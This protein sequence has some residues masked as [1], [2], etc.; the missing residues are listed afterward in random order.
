LANATYKGTLAGVNTGIATVTVTNP[1]GAGVGDWM[2]VE[3][4]TSSSSSTVTT[5]PAGWVLLADSGPVNTRHAFSYAKI[6]TAD[7]PSSWDFILNAAS[8][9]SWSIIYGAGGLGISDWKKRTY[10]NDVNTAFGYDRRYTYYLEQ[11]AASSASA[12]YVTRI[13]GNIEAVAG[14]LVITWAGEATSAAETED[15]ITATG[16]TKKL[17]YPGSGSLIYTHWIGADTMTAAGMTNDVFVTY[18]NLQNS[19]GM[20]HQIVIPPTV[21]APTTPSMTRVVAYDAEDATMPFSKQVLADSFERTTVNP[22]SGA[23]SYRRVLG[24]GAGSGST[25][26]SKVPTGPLAAAKLQMQ[27]AAT[28]PEG[29]GLLVLGDSMLEG[30]GQTAVEKRIVDMLAA[31]IATLVEAKG[32]SP[33]V[34]AFYN[35]AYNNPSQPPVNAGPVWSGSKTVTTIPGLGRRAYA[36]GINATVTLTRVVS[37]MDVHMVM[38]TNDQITIKWGTA[39]PIT[40]GP[41]LVGH[42]VFKDPAGIASTPRSRACLIARVAGGPV[43][44]GYMAYTNNETTGVRVLDASKHGTM[45]YQFTSVRGPNGDGWHPSLDEQKYHMGLLGHVTNDTKNGETAQTWTD[46]TLRNINVL[47]TRANDGRLP[48]LIFFPWEPYKL[49]AGIWATFRA[50]AEAIKANDQYVE[51]ADFSTVIKSQQEKIDQDLLAVND[52]IHWNDKGALMAEQFL[53]NVITEN[54]T[55]TKYVAPTGGTGNGRPLPTSHAQAVTGTAG[56]SATPEGYIYEGWVRLDSDTDIALG[57]LTI[58]ATG[59]GTGGIQAL[60]DARNGTDNASTFQLKYAM[61]VQPVAKTS[62]S[63]FPVSKGQKYR[64]RILWKQT[65]PVVTAYFY[66]AAGTL[67]QTLTTTTDYPAGRLG[68][69]SYGSVTF[70]DL[71]FDKLAASAAITDEVELFMVDANGVTQNGYLRLYDGT[72][73][74]KAERFIPMPSGLKVSQL[75]TSNKRP[76][77]AHRGGSLDYSEHSARGYTQCVMLGVDILE[78]SVGRTSD[79]VFFGLHDIDLNRTTPELAA[80]YLASAHTWSEISALTQVVPS[81][82]DSTFGRQPYMKLT[83]LAVYFKSHTIF[84]D[85]KYVTGANFTALLN[86]LLTY[87]NATD[88]FVIKYFHTATSLATQAKNAGFKTWGYYY[89]ADLDGTNATQIEATAQYWDFLGLEYTATQALWTKIKSFNKPVFAHI[90]PTAAAAATAIA[91]GADALQV[92]GVRSVMSVY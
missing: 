87:P 74:I 56:Y 13:R 29:F 91:K 81:G 64:I 24:T 11:Q 92:S 17:W 68:I 59:E 61:G 57:G 40:Y 18:P 85:P 33:Y 77:M 36:M 63:A 53:L 43:V 45:A 38:S 2:I 78:F 79:G 84:I 82:G 21:D 50:A 23:A 20:G 27:K 30:T 37:S 69:Y 62:P 72:Q 76:I 7:D 34:P 73:I 32:G 90:V 39:A 48:I 75:F 22:I 52:G 88:T 55:L 6:K 80:N 25:G 31:D 46:A 66:N 86:L 70:D 12:G 67:M 58:G 28:D 49:G 44:R 35:F 4:L 47:R 16:A 14:A 41:G 3:L 5:V 89:T 1:S 65:D 26:G 51:F 71:T 8:G 60:I 10:L 19:N 54:K 83:D 9:T 15:Q 42:K